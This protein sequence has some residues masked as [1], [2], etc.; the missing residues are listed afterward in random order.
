M[1]QHH[2]ENSFCVEKKKCNNP[3]HQ[4]QL[5]GKA[6]N[7]PPRG[8]ERGGEGPDTKPLTGSC[9]FY[10]SLPS[11]PEGLILRPSPNLLD[12]YAALLLTGELRVL[13]ICQ[14]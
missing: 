9:F 12:C 1:L 2:T 11:P 5:N 4:K 6:N 8:E 13:Y 10:P 7:I 3:S 14:N